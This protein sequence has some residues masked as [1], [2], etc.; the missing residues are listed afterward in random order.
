MCTI[1]RFLLILIGNQLMQLV[2]RDAEESD[3]PLVHAINDAA[4]PEVN[5]VPAQFFTHWLEH[6]FYL[7]VAVVDGEVIGFLLAM[8][9]KAV[10]G[11]VNYQWFKENYSRFVYIDRIVVTPLHRSKGV[12]HGL[13][14]DLIAYVGGKS[15]LLGCEVN[16]RP[17]NETSLRFHDVMKF[18]EVG[19]QNT[20]GGAKTVALLARYFEPEG[21]ERED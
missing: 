7:R 16:V 1:A 12:G 18:K 8:N 4:Q 9:Q 13:Y 2:I 14:E 21:A 19:R 11:S 20:E 6:A 10:Y 5:G 15:P 17:R 3:L